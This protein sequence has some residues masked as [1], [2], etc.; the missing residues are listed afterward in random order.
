ME[1]TDINI[2]SYPNSEKIYID[3]TLFPIKVGMRKINLTP[4]VKIENGEKKI[5]P[6]APVVVYDTSGAYTDKN[7]K[8]DINEGLPRLR[9]QLIADRNDTVQ[10]DSITSDYGKMR[11]Q[12]KSLDG[13]RFKKQYKP[14]KAKP[15]K[16]ITQMAYAKAGIIT[17]E[18]EYVAIRENLNNKELGIE[19]YITPE[20]VRDEIAAGRAIIP[21]NINHPEAEPMIIGRAFSVKLNTNIG[22][23]A[24]SSGI[25]EE[26]DKAMWSCYWGGD[27]LMDLSTG[28]NIHETR[29]W[30]IRNCPV[31]MGTV[32][33]YQALEKV[34]G[35]VAELTWEIYRDTL[36][37]QCE[38]GVDYFTIHAGVL[39]A[40]AQLIGERL[41]GV[42]SRGGSIMTQ[43]CVLHNQESFLYT[44]FDEICEI[45]AQYDVAVS[46]GDGMRPGSIYDANDKAQFLELDVLG[47]LTEKAW[48][49][50]VQVIIEGPGHVPMQKI[51]ENMDKQLSACHEAPFYTLGPLT[52]DVAPGYD[53]I[54]SAIGAAQIA[55][56]GTAMICYVTPKEHLSLP[57]KEDVRNGVIAYK[58]AAHAA[59]LAKGFPGAQVRDNAMSKARFEFRWKDQFNLSLDPA[60]AK[61]YYVESHES[62]DK[63]CTMCGPN[64]CAM[65]ITQKVSEEICK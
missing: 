28:D 31:P 42:V 23:S 25:K 51:R 32:P 59:D 49:H 3:G 22:N 52:T 34:Q 43:W 44:H 19:S 65:R 20:F 60:R 21:A 18:M 12:D 5:I 15:G 29:E 39:K 37:E 61:Q 24:L 55:W 46:L 10:L 40:H 7:I 57:N 17:A 38:Q 48:K 14:R 53:H 41:T 9:E 45:L 1:F 4:T 62:D 6:N 50:N 56:Y 64:F 8:T 36:I 54:T 16:E 33:I 27:T 63:F 35:N 13:I 26:V 30:I 47:E 58:I 11:L 2:S